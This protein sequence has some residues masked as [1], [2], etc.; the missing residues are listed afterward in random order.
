M[1]KIFMFHFCKSK[2]V[3]FV[4]L[5]ELAEKMAD[6]IF[7]SKKQ[8]RLRRVYKILKICGWLFAVLF[9]IL[10]ITFSVKILS[11]IKV[12]DQASLGKANLE[13]AIILSQQDKL[14]QAMSAALAA[15]NNFTASINRLDE[16]KNG[17]A[18][19]KFGLAVNQLNDI[20]S[21]LTAAQFLSKA[22][23]GGAGFGLSLESL[24]VG[25][26]KLNFS[27]FSPEEK[28]QVL[29]KLYESAPE[30]NGIKADL[31]LAYLNLEQADAEGLLLPFKGKISQIKKKR[32]L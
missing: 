17:Y 7:L 28:H 5:H 10:L 16:I 29:G 13:K 21:L 9:I 8:R 31:D 26:K 3:N 27:K 6:G 20:E 30:L 32:R 1:S 22:V 15:E 14:S 4:R 2:H 25:D 11:L 23:K 24:L 19:D 12:Y 18:V